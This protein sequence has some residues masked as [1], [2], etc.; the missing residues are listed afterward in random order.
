MFHILAILKRREDLS[1]ED[2]Q[3][4]WRGPHAD[5]ARKIP[6]LRRCVQN[7]TLL[8]GY[9]AHS[10]ICD[11]VA[12]LWFDDAA[13]FERAN[14][15]PEMAAAQADLEEFVSKEGARIMR[16]ESRSIVAGAAPADGVKLISFLTRRQDLSREQFSAHWHD[17]HGPIAARIPGMRRYLQY[18]AVEDARFG[19]TLYDGVPV[20][21]FEDT[22]ALRA[23]EPSDAYARTRADEAHFLEPDRI[24]FVI[25]REFE[26]LD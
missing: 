7:R 22:D 5:L 26:V 9:R 17:R 21:W 16:L 15:S 13:G 19:P 2:F 6:G 14:A 4:H 10:P 25:A 3:A 1:P 23:S 18:H 24:R 11:G 12:E 8:S 20:A